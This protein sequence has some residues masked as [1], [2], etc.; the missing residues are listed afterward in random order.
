[1]KYPSVFNEQSNDILFKINK[2]EAA[3]AAAPSSTTTATSIHCPKP[4]INC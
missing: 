1:M 4:I 3:A 2:Q